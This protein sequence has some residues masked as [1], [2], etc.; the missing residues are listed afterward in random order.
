MLD[1]EPDPAAC[2]PRLPSD[3]PLPRRARDERRVHRI[4]RD[5]IAEER[6]EPS[7]DI[8][9][10][11]LKRSVASDTSTATV[12]CRMVNGAS[13]RSRARRPGSASAS[14]SIWRAK[15]C[16]RARRAARRSARAAVTRIRGGGGRAEAITMDVTSEADVVRLAAR[17]RRS[18]GRLDIM[19]CNAGFGYYGTR[20]RDASRRHAPDDGRQ[21]HGHVL[22]RA[23]RAADLPRAGK[24]PPGLLSSIVGSRGIP[25]MSGYSA[26]KAAQVGFRRVAPLGVRRHGHPRQR[27]V[28]GVDDH[29]VPQ[30]MERDF[31]HPVAG[32]RAE[33]DRSTTS[34]ARS[35][36]AS[37]GRAPRS[38]RTASRA[39][40]S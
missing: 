7:V 26:T 11:R 16:G 30:A 2:A 22:R 25:I 31:G 29:G 13:P 28:P 17:A 12:S 24:R 19:I 38:T 36:V 32:P 3:L 18:Y 5:E 23:R 20:R 33:A 9:V 39:S 10:Q 21:L 1:V 27:G 15:A 6:D 37:S 4:D 34:R 35:C 14:R 8:R 40:R